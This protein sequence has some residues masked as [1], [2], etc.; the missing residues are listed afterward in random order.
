VALSRDIVIRLL[1]DAD[2]AVKA[3]KA[4]AD[5]AEV[6][7]QQ[8]RKA[9]REYDRSQKAMETA[10]R[11]QRAAM[12]DVGRGSLIAG[13][14]IVAG[15]GMAVKAAMD[16]E[17]AWAGVRK[18]VNGSEA[19][20][21]K[22]EKGL[23]GL[24]QTLPATHEE[25]AAVAEAAGQLGV[26]TGNIVDFTR[27]M[28]NLG[29]TTNLSADQAATSLAQFMNVMGTAPKDVGR[30]GATLVALGNAG[31]STEADIVNMASYITGSAKLIGASDSD[32]LALANAMTS[33]G[34]NAERGGGV[35]TR[36]MQDVYSAVQSGGDKLD[37]FAKV[38]GT[39]SADFAKAFRE[40]P[41]RAIDSFIK[42]LDTVEKSGGNVISTLG[43]LGYKGTQDTAVL[44][45]LKGAGDL[46]TDSLD[47]GNKAWDQ[48]SALLIEAAK[49]Y[50]TTAAKTEMARNAIN[51]AA[52]EIGDTFLPVLASLAG[53]VA[54]VAKWFADLPSPIQSAI[55]GIAGVAGVAG[56]AG[57]AFLLLAPRIM[58]TYK[59]FQLLNE[60]M[61][62]LA[63]E[64]GHSRQGCRGRLRGLRC[65]VPPSRPST[66][67]W[68]LLR[69]RWSS[70]PLP[71][72]TWTALS[73]S[74][75]KRFAL[76]TRH[77]DQHRRIQRRDQA[78]D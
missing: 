39:S 50:D 62:R 43:D 18:T 36:V 67:R 56:L 77:H 78:P 1:G 26:Q 37:A 74:L 44:L 53:G 75:D 2:S 69:G 58:E 8:Y 35:M 11:K 40:D 70:T 34:I 49:R 41:I 59:A 76:S 32:V 30:L 22:L 68:R 46:L 28:V 19:E 7:V 21:A 47:L 10:A 23:R 55:G 25:I 33:M 12:E 61:P 48:N 57:G 73:T 60:T 31:A 63:V 9:E 65:S 64:H 3:Q 72:W 42:G 45:Q 71:C 6:T 24:A 27:T 51:D 5:A 52:I 66:M 17:S 4:A 16:W 54:D 29:E 14:A 15:L 13:G 38:A 20:L